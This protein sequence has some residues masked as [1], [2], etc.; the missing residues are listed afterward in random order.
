MELRIIASCVSPSAEDTEALGHG[1]GQIVPA[2]LLIALHGDLGTGKTCLVRGLARGLGLE[3]PI[4]SPSYT[5]MQT[6]EGGRLSLHHFDAWMEGRQKAFLGDGALETW[7]GEGISVV[8]WAERVGDWLPDPHVVITLRY[9]E[10]GRSM[11]ERHIQVGIRGQ[12][13]M[14]WLEVGLEALK[15]GGNLAWMDPKKPEEGE[16]QPPRGVGGNVD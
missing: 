3:R 10:E 7:E 14:P 1:L 11:N 13:S 6:H 4:S 2:G 16:P 5:L 15:Q 12:G 8:E 9:P